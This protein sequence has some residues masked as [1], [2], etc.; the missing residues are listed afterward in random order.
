MKNKIYKRFSGSSTHKLSCYFCGVKT[1]QHEAIVSENIRIDISIC[2][3]C[4]D[5]NNM[6]LLS[7]FSLV[8][9]NKKL[10]SVI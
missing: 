6:N 8:V 7:N 9:K 10:I 1:G 3:K 5:N 2:E 4:Q